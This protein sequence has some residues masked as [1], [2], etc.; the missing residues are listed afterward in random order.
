MIHCIDDVVGHLHYVNNLLLPDID[1][2]N[3]LNTLSS[4]L[5]AQENIEMIQIEVF[6]SLPP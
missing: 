2:H 3:Y 5:Y 1:H 4:H 6:I